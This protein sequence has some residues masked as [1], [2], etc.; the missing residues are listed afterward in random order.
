MDDP[1]PIRGDF[2]APAVSAEAKQRLDA[3]RMNDKLS[4]RVLLV[5]GSRL[6]VES[7]VCAG[8]EVFV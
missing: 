5:D 4:E 7:A 2:F 8:A 6:I 3:K 1:L